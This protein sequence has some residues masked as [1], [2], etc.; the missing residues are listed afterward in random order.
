[1]ARHAASDVHVVHEGLGE[2]EPAAV[3]VLELVPEGLPAV[4]ADLDAEAEQGFAGG[5]RRGGV[6]EGPQDDALRCGPAGDR[7]KRCFLGGD[8]EQGRGEDESR[9]SQGGD[10]AGAVE[11][12]QGGRVAALA[13]EE[14][15]RFGAGAEPGNELV[16][17]DAGA[18]LEAPEPGVDGRLRHVERGLACEVAGAEP[19]ETALVIVELIEAAGD[20][21]EQPGDAGGGFGVVGSTIGDVLCGEDGGEH[22]AVALHA[23][24]LRDLEA[25]R[26][27][28]R[29]GEL[30]LL[31]VLGG[32]GCVRA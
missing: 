10:V 15:D 27:V 13:G 2:D 20:R 9:G 12:A 4:L 30:A 26:V 11:G 32:R 29:D 14:A 5:E 7:Q 28:L 3:R 17:A 21:L 19:G 24:G 22:A 8:G 18:E 31:G 16:G 1:M 23:R 25:P 6:R